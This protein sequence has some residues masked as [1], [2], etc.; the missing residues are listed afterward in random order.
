M[1][2]AFVYDSEVEALRAE[3]R[4]AVWCL[5]GSIGLIAGAVWAGRRSRREP[6][7]ES[8]TGVRREK[9]AG[10]AA[11]RAKQKDESIM[12]RAVEQTPSA[13]GASDEL[14]VL[15]REPA[16]DGT[17]MPRQKLLRPMRVT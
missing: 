11:P 8:K 14:P 16:R 4:T 2:R 1:H 9:D 7:L 5:G 3:N 12:N 10:H 17:P 15:T 6:S 13:S